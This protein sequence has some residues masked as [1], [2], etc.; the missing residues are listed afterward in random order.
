M[1]LDHYHKDRAYH[2]TI[3][4]EYDRVVVHPRALINDALFRPLLARLPRPQT[5]LDLG[6]GTGHMLT[7]LGGL[8]KPIRM[9]GV[10][11][12]E[13]ML[14]Q[15]RLNTQK[16]TGIDLQFIHSD[17]FEFM[18]QSKETYDLISCVGVLHHLRPEQL[19]G[20]LVGCRKRLREQGHLLVAEPVDCRSL[21]D[22]LPAWIASRNARSPATGLQYHRHAEDPDEHPLAEGR[23]LEALQLAGFDLIGQRRAVEVFAVKD[24]ASIIDRLIARWV[25]HQFRHDGYIHAVLATPAAVPLRR[26]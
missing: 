22:P 17:V 2:D 10:D 26:P 24:R 21:R 19:D 8:L 13:G 14:A 18:R 6:C 25:C 1:T 11:H 16:F 15:A 20:F 4:D 3:A 12:S 7:R 5:Y 9:T 23:L